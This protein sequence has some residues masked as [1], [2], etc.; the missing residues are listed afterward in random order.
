[1]DKFFE[2]H[3][4]YYFLKDALSLLGPVMKLD[5]LAENIADGKHESSPTCQD[6]SDVSR[7]FLS[8][9]HVVY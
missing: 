1:V 8:E 7:C 5:S 9:F 3:C 6:V 2:Q 4:A